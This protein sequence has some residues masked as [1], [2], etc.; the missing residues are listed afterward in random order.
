MRAAADGT[1]ASGDVTVRFFAPGSSTPSAPG[2]MPEPEPDQEPE[3]EPASEPEPDRFSDVIGHWAERMI[4]A[5]AEMGWIQGYED[6][7]FRPDRSVTR[8]EMAVILA[9]VLELSAQTGMAVTGFADDDAIAAWAR[10]AV[11]ALVEAGLLTGYED[12]T[13]RP[14]QTLTRAEMAVLLMRALISQG[15]T[16]WSNVAATGFADDD[17]IPAWARAAVAVLAEAGL[18]EGDADGS[19]HPHRP[20]TRAEA[21]TLMVRIAERLGLID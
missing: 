18:I 13:F 14:G 9:R 21:V 11:S 17:A 20:L 4:A 6:G 5:A 1:P 2:P 3:P 7:S 8:A 15:L 19:F 16:E 12:G 10:A